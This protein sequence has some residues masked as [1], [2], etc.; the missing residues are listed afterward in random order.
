MGDDSECLAV[1]VKRGRGRPRKYPLKEEV[2]AVAEVKVKRPIGRPRIHPLKEEKKRRG[3]PKLYKKM[4][5]PKKFYGVVSC[6][7]TSIYIPTTLAVSV[8][9]YC[10]ENGLSWGDFSTLAFLLYFKTMKK[11]EK[12]YPEM[13]RWINALIRGVKWPRGGRRKGSGRKKK[14]DDE[15]G[16]GGDKD[17]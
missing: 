15:A 3:R 14:D 4:G 5:R 7:R 12:P 17:G 1:Q 9:E 2:E 13:L 8:R 16:A 10:A 11:M 6:S